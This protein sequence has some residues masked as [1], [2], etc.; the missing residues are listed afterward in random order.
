M[1][2]E[3]KIPTAAEKRKQLT[4]AKE[5]RLKDKV[6]EE[7]DYIK[8]H[9]DRIIEYVAGE[10]SSMDRRKLIIEINKHTKMKLSEKS[11]RVISS[12]VK[13]KFSPLGYKVLFFPTYTVWCNNEGQVKTRT[14]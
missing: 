12:L 5:K 2:S 14:L 11:C 6:L 9:K 13:E 10:I 7:E 1:Q 3:R 8:Q 4:E